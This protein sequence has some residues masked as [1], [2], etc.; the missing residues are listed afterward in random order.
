MI[1]VS[2]EF[3]RYMAED[4]RDFLVWL[5][6]KLKNGRVLKLDNS[7]LWENTLKINDGVTPSG[8]FTIGSCISNKLAFTL[9]N[10]Y[11]DFSMYDF[12]GSEV[13]IYLGLELNGKI[14][15]IRKGTF[16]VDESK[17]DG[18]TITLECLDYM[19]RLDQDY[20]EVNTRYPS[21]LKEIVMDICDYCQVELHT[22]DFD[23]SGY[24]VKERPDDEKLTC[25]QVLLYCAQIACKYARFNTDGL[26]CLEWFNTDV[27][28]KNGSL[29][30]GFFDKHAPYESGDAADGGSLYEDMLGFDA[31][32]GFFKDMDSFH[33]LY[34][35]SSFSVN[36]DN[37][38][39]TGV[40]VT[41][42]CEETKYY[43][44]QT[45]LAGEEGYVLAV[46]DNQLIQKRQADIVAPYL[47]E[48][49]TGIKFR[50]LSMQVLS[51]PTVEAGDVA[52]VTDYKHNTYQCLITNLTF[53]LGGFMEVSCDAET[54]GKNN[55]KQYTELSRAVAQTRKSAS[56]NDA[57]TGSRVAV[58]TSYS[59]AADISLAVLGK[60]ATVTIPDGVCLEFVN[61]L[62]VGGKRAN[63]DSI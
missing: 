28:I 32:A 51:D 54:A 46:S 20:K 38:I 52:Y 62:L 16:V 10:I 26:L 22:P 35:M 15:K 17:Y 44:P 47:G 13:I 33:H 6:L 25:R 55:A 61:G 2:N 9:N 19:S 1:N 7:H 36:T 60:T 39:V 40:R 63:G 3:K 59:R 42:D 11:D 5:D 48:K 37:V 21:T 30:G 24:I 4:G 58:Q 12:E 18:S 34:S 29:E 49:L 57:V 50:P 14:E 56:N 45:V 27:F 41:E 43:K 23:D 53:Q 8:E 31:D